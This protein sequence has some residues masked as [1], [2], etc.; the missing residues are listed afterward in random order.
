LVIDGF[1]NRD[2]GKRRATQYRSPWDVLHP[3]RLFAEKLADGGATP[4][5]LLARL[6]EYFSGRPVPLVPMEDA[7]DVGTTEDEEEAE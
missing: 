5:T 6:D 7:T 1:G 3:G 4:E 2:P